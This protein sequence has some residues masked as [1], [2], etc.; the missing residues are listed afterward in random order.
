MNTTAIYAISP[1]TTAIA[2]GIQGA[3]KSQLAAGSPSA[4]QRLG[5]PKIQRWLGPQKK[6]QQ[7][8]I[9]SYSSWMISWKIS[10]KWDDHWGY[11]LV[12]TNIAIENDHI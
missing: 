3:T 8:E 6:Q 2:Q 4:G 10:R 7:H 12:M 1:S 5:V 9:W 11:P